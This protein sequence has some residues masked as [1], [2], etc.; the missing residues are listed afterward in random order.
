[1]IPILGAHVSASGGLYRAFESAKKIGA[2]AIQI[3][4]SSPQQWSV[5]FPSEEDI[6]K[7]K[8][9]HK[10][11]GN[12]PVFLHASYLANLASPN[13]ITRANALQSLTGHLKIADSID[14]QGLVFH[15]GSGKDQSK[16]DALKLVVEGCQKIL[17]NVPGKTQLI[18][19]NSSAGGAKLGATPQEIGQILKKI[20]SPRAKVCFD[21][22]HA[23]EAGMIEYDSLAKIKTV[24]DEWGRE[25][26]LANIVAIHANDSK[27][28]FASHNDRHENLGQGHIG[29]KGFQN[30]AKEK[31]LHN[32][33]WL[34]EVPGFD[35]LGPDKKNI[36]I[37]KSCF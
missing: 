29:I 22:A 9:A 23:F 37:L 16:E 17:K 8:S 32:K 2:E 3:F 30:L 27:T 12:I 1:M 20:N 14:A 21:T 7:F 10:E 4:G 36:E 15:I 33:V 19:E 25:V 18:L 13:E 34:L 6:K 35:G 31:R 24:F 11:S 28:L 5:R 26:G